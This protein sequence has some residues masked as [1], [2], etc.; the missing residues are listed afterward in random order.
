MRCATGP[1]PARQVST[2]CNR[3]GPFT[4]VLSLTRFDSG[5]HL[6][7]SLVAG[8][9]AK[10]HPPVTLLGFDD[11]KDAIE[12]WSRELL[13][14]SSPATAYTA[15]I[16]YHWYAGDHFDNLA[17]AA[18]AYPDK[19][20]LGTEATYEL[21]RLG[22][23]SASHEDWVRHGVWARGEGYAHAIIGDLCAGSAG[24]IDW[25]VLLDATGGPNHL[26]NTCDAPMVAD[27]SFDQV[28]LHPQF[29]FLGHFCGL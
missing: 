22:D 7:P 2:R 3:S 23:P 19:I 29:H 28:Y 9:A 27:S 18:A 15:G 16:A 24:W 1:E 6:G 8:A 5:A 21:T 4:R 25:N 11:Q 20:F 26:N 12:S 13:G 10:H 14:A 17:R